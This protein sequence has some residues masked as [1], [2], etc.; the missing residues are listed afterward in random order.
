VRVL[1][2]STYEL[3]HQPL[4]V[5]SPAGALRRAGHDV[6]CADLSIGPLDAGDVAWAEAVAC[7]VPMH[8]AMRMTRSVCSGIRERRPDVPVCVYGLY[9]VLDGAEGRTP[10]A[11]VAFAGEYEPGLVSWVA[12]GAPR[13]RPD[14][15]LPR[16]VP[17]PAR[18]D[19]ARPVTVSL[20][21]SAFGLPAR[22]LLPALDHYARL[23]IA[24]EE[25]LAGYVEASHGCAHRCRHCPVPVV[26]DGRTR[27][28]AEDAVVAD[29]AQLVEAGAR[30]ITFGDPDFLN[31]PH[32]ARRVVE[33]VHGSFPGLTFDLTVKV[34]H[35]LG[36]RDLWP[37]FAAAGVVFVV[38]AFES[39]SDE[40]LARLA[41]G[42]TVAE[43]VEA[44]G[45]LGGHQLPR[46]AGLGLTA[47]GEVDVDPTG[48]KAL[49]VPGR[50]SVAEEDQIGHVSE[51]SRVVLPGLT[52]PA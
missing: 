6:R 29:V 35:V 14:R 43:E 16:R 21:R 44:V 32:H 3:G 8:T 45:L 47:E 33:A 37:S 5:A 9:A 18:H 39:A 30:H 1:L 41:K 10:S 40:I 52:D 22:D 36:R 34:E 15:P 28:V 12:D 38:S 42:H 13:H 7:S 19:D 31:G 17:S 48:E 46:L 50:L 20:G 2:V 4:H 26:Y 25:R 24:G 11:D 27:I 23:C 51:G 49:G